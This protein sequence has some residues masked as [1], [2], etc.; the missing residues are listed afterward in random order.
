MFPFCAL[1]AALVEKQKVLV[2]F[3]VPIARFSGYRNS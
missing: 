3:I 1:G 2:C